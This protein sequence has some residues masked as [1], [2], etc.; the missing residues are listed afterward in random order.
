MTAH[1]MTANEKNAVHE[2]FVRLVNIPPAQLKAWLASEESRSV[3]M[4][5]DGDKVTGSSHAESVRHQMGERILQIHSKK[6]DGLSEQDFADMRKVIGYI[7]RHSA[8]RPK[9]DVTDTRWRKSL[10]QWEIP[11][12]CRGGSRSLTFPGV[13]L[14]Y[15]ST[16]HRRL[17]GSSTR[18]FPR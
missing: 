11:R 7:H 9:G 16:R 15:L 5:P 18:M 13:S 4:T 8:Q 1:S 6:A 2:E 17:C 10:I 3:G 14:G 12:L